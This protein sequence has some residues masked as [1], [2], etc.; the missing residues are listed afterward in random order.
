[1]KDLYNENYKA[2]KK[3]PEDGR[4]SHVHVLTEIIL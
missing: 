1:M 4:T 3:L 2:L